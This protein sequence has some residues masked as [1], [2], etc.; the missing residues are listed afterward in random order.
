MFEVT[1]RPPNSFIY[2]NNSSS[3]N[4]NNANN[5]NSSSYQSSNFINNFNQPRRNQ[6]VNIKPRSTS[7]HTSNVNNYDKNDVN[8]IDS[9][10]NNLN[11][12]NNSN[13]NSSN[14]RTYS[15]SS[16]ILPKSPALP[17]M[18]I[19]S[20]SNNSNFVTRVL[21]NNNNNNTNR[22][23][24]SSSAT[25][26][27]PKLN[28]DIIN[29]HFNND[30]TLSDFALYKKNK[31]NNNIN[32]TN[33][34]SF[35][36][37]KSPNTVTILP[38]YYETKES[39]IKTRLPLIN[40]NTS[41]ND[42]NINNNSSS[43]NNS[44]NNVPNI[45][46]NSASEGVGSALSAIN[47]NNNNNNNSN[48]TGNYI[49]NSN[50]NNN[51]NNNKSPPS[52]YSP[53]HHFHQ[54]HQSVI[55]K[56]ESYLIPINLQT[57]NRNNYSTNNLNSNNENSLYEV[58]VR[59]PSAKQVSS[60]KSVKTRGDML[61]DRQIGLTLNNSFNNHNNSNNNNS[62]TQ[63]NNGTPI[64][65]TTSANP[66]T[67]PRIVYDPRVDGEKDY[68]K[69]VVTNPNERKFPKTEYHSYYVPTN[70]NSNQSNLITLPTFFRT[71]L[72]NL[73]SKTLYENNNNFSTNGYSNSHTTSNGNIGTP[74]KKAQKSIL[75]NKKR[76]AN[77]P[78]IPNTPS[79]P[80]KT[81]TFADET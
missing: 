51:N 70:N 1:T 71:S 6:V 28:E 7:V 12:N 50:N 39:A 77:P 67:S 38:V 16:Y 72:G 9:F 74:S 3:S 80:K 33:S 64:R 14:G 81:V 18:P 55:N 35:N 21:S 54:P 59:I 24:L 10:T 65:F 47:N 34:P 13:N 5:N 73:N 17:H 27:K 42:N 23:L 75:V 4:Q 15:S 46:S 66:A 49:F 52:I 43:N 41:I 78:H 26:L 60:I 61:N 62:Y 8:L 79:T 40:I 20:P 68:N 31:Q 37:P 36:N 48:Q 2:N 29:N 45:I 30:D 44:E 56:Q 53:S 63:S 22:N 76:F 25:Y 19:I 57:S 32:T 58:P 11:L 69:Y